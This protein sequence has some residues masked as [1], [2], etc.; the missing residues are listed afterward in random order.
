MRRVRQGAIALVGRR[1]FKH[2]ERWLAGRGGYVCMCV[3]MHEQCSPSRGLRS[4]LALKRLTI[5]VETE[6]VFVVVQTA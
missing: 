2:A 1:L 6:I 5:G 3:R 4:P